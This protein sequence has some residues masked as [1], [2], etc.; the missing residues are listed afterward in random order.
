MMDKGA[1]VGSIGTLFSF[2]LGQ[3]SHIAGIVSALITIIYMLI[4]IRKSL[5]EK[6]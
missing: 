5:N 2:T 6:S 3:W 4:R 1:I